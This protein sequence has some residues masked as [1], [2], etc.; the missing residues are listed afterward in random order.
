M[1]TTAIVTGATRGIGRGVVEALVASGA[2][3]GCIARSADDLAEL[4]AAVAAPGIVEVAAADLSRRDEAEEAVRTLAEALGPVDLLV[5]NAGVGLYGPV[6]DLDP[7]EAER[8]IRI[9]YLSVVYTTGAVLPAM[10]E[11]RSGHIVNVASIA[12]RLGAPFEAAYSASKFAVVGFS[13]ALAVE[14]AALGVRVSVVNPGPVDT[15]FFA[16]RGHPYER[17]S[18][19]PIA[20]AEAVAA[21]LAAIAS[22]RFET[23]V[24]ASL[25]MARLTRALLPRLYFLGVRRAFRPELSTLACRAEAAVNGARRATS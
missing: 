6:L 8:L 4:S 11:R 9:N 20:V 14:A 12:G 2:R 13:E 18:P 1:P 17:E 25:K 7:E 21:V 24:P 15:E 16:R 22:G 5:N 19:K 23:T 3:V 10:A